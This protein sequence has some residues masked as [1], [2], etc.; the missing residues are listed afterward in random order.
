MDMEKIMYFML[1]C[2]WGMGIIGGFGSTLYCK[3]WPCAVGVIVV[4]L[5]SWDAVKECARKLMD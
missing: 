5:M 4:G 2:L 1:I 3:A